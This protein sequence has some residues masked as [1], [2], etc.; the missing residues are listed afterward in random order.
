MTKKLFD[1]VLDSLRSQWAEG[2][3][4][5]GKTWSKSTIA[6]LSF[7]GGAVFGCPVMDRIL[8]HVV[9]YGLIDRGLVATNNGIGR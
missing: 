3:D 9:P 7:R 5:L 4:R 8:S 1:H 6:S 2:S